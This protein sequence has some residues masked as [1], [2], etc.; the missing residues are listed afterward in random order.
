MVL[1]ED[2]IISMRHSVMMIPVMPA[3]RVTA[4]N[5]PP[6]GFC[7]IYTHTHAN[8]LHTMEGSQAEVPRYKMHSV[9]CNRYFH[10]PLHNPYH[11]L[12]T[13]GFEIDISSF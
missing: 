6:S 7:K 5:R 3:N 2:V 1:V 11:S 10:D 4:T 13:S 8:T 12:Q 9:L